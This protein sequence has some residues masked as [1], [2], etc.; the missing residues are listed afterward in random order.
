MNITDCDLIIYARFVHG[1]FGKEQHSVFQGLK[2]RNAAMT[3]NVILFKIPQK[4]CGGI[5]PRNLDSW[6]AIYD[7]FL[8]IFET[9][10]KSNQF[11]IPGFIPDFYGPS[12][13][14]IVK[15]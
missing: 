11:Q 6:Q 4:V 14:T 2:L 8:T 3:E 7:I 10:L 9:D 13:Q 1:I 15:T 5:S 12:Y